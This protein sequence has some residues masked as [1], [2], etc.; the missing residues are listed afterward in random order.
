M[1]SVRRT[2]YGVQRVFFLGTPVAV[3]CAIFLCGCVRVAGGAG[4][5]HTNPEGGTTAKQA[6]FDTAD[7]VPG[8][9][10]PGKITI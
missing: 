4:Y 5:W 3:L 10:T 6:G 7:Y 8:H 1:S 9:S 2:P